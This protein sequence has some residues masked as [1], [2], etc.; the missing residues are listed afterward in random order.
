M[1]EGPFVCA[2]RGEALFVLVLVLVQL[3]A[4][5][6][7]GARGARLLLGLGYAGVLDGGQ[8]IGGVSDGQV[9]TVAAVT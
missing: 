7:H 6:G 1:L 9:L 8:L 4:V 5:G 2:W 3:L